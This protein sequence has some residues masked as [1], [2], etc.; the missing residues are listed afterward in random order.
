MSS[1]KRVELP[2][3]PLS[4]VLTVVGDA[5]IELRQSDVVSTRVGLKAFGLASL[6]ADWRSPFFVVSANTS[7]TDAALRSALIHLGVKPDRRLIVRSSGVAESMASRGSLESAECD[8]AGLA[9]QIDNLRNALAAREATRISEVHWVVQQCIAVKAKGHLSNERRV[10]EDKRDWVVEVEVSLTNPVEANRISLRN[11]RDNC[12]P[13]NGPLLCPYRAQ[14]IQCL[15]S[16]AK[17]AY[18]RLIRVH[19]EWVWDGSRIFLVQADVCDENSSGVEPKDC[20]HL[21]QGTSVETGRLKLFREATEEDY[22]QYG[23]L[24]NARLY[25][26]LAYQTVSFFVLSDQDEILALVER[27]QCSDELLHDLNLLVVRPLVIRTDGLTIA[28][29]LRQMLPRSEELR[30]ANEAVTWLLGKFRKDVLQELSNNGVTILDGKPCLIAHHFVPSTAAAWCQASPDQRR[31]RIESLWGLPEGLYWYAYDAFDVDT[32]ES[33]LDAST[34]RPE[35]MVIRERR[36]Y[37]ERF[38]APDADGHWVLHKTAAG[39]DWQRSIKCRAWIEEIAWTSRCISSKLGFPVVV[40]WFVDVPRTVSNHHVLPWYHEV[41]KTGASPHKAAPRKKLSSTADVVL[42]VRADWDSLKSRLA[43]GEQI[44][45]IRVQPDE[46]EMVRDREFAEEL[47]AFSDKHKLIVELEGGLLS[48]AYYMLSRA[49]CTVECAD[50]DNYATDDQ[51]LEFHKLV[52]DKIP[53]AIL[54]KGESVV[55]TRLTGEALIAALRRKLVEE[56]L[57]VMDARTAEDVADELADVREVVLSLMSRL[58]IAEADVESRRKSK[59][60]ARGAFDDALMLS[61]TAVAPSMGFRQLD[62]KYGDKLSLISSTID[63]EAAIPAAI[64]EL[65]VDRRLDAAGIAERQFTVSVPAHVAGY[66]PMRAQFGL[67]TANGGNHD[68]IFELL[69]GRQGGNLRIRARVLNS[70][71]QLKLDLDDATS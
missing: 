21:P 4:S 15:T 34:I 53:E 71:V 20:V 46:P 63:Q 11:W 49:G 5:V 10:A 25:R 57:E 23:K 16:V 65:H 60:K 8:V 62:I 3:S 1:S 50:L 47:A 24:A 6:P 44:V 61:K 68:M 52:R 38:V 51:E 13:N 30:T 45:R 55:V 43:S 28:T 41:W 69:I 18:E 26:E 9:A 17:W 32:K 19:F 12:P 14:Y 64:E 59:A 29:E 54:A 31:V 27:S 22:T 36:R 37:K 39:P 35:R 67:P 2:L 66:R 33:K 58:G 7:P 70:A 42:R 48:H 40:M 56:S